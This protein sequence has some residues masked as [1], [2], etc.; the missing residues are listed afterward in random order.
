MVALVATFSIWAF[1]VHGFFCLSLVPR[2][3]S[4]Q[5]FEASGYLIRGEVPFTT[6]IFRN[7]ACRITQRQ[8]GQ[9]LSF[10]TVRKLLLAFLLTAVSTRALA[11]ESAQQQ[12]V[13]PELV[14]AI[15]RPIL[16]LREESIA[17]CGEPGM[18]TEPKCLT[19]DGY[20]R[21]QTRWWKVAEG[22]GAVIA[23]KGAT[24]DEAFVV[25]MCYYTG[26][27]G[28]DID[29]VINRGRRML[30]YLQQYRTR[31]TTIPKRHTL[32]LSG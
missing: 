32:S 15:V 11:G 26:E 2:T 20:D 8:T 9:M 13:V 31:V 29:A 1:G 19:G 5:G 24:A 27:Y 7:V 16:D 22:V 4:A 30:P 14:A 28:D 10:L 17:D 21:E 12:V 25:L 23:Q 6:L 3:K 18:P